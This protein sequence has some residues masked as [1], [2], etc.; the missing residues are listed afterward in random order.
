MSIWWPIRGCENG[1]FE[2][3]EILHYFLLL[4]ICIIAPKMHKCCSLHNFC[5]IGRITNP[6]VLSVCVHGWEM[7]K[8]KRMWLCSIFCSIPEFCIVSAPVMESSICCDFNF[9]NVDV[10]LLMW[11]ITI[12]A[13][14]K[15]MQSSECVICIG[16]YNLLKPTGNSV[17]LNYHCLLRT[18]LC[19]YLSGKFISLTKCRPSGGSLLNHTFSHL[20]GLSI[21]LGLGDGT[22]N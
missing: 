3:C 8:W 14:N 19:I 2:K 6:P 22:L 9:I 17:S 21:L 11:I 10:S 7:E 5:L 4:E 15:V 18:L 1:H 13:E 12:H 16:G 20:P